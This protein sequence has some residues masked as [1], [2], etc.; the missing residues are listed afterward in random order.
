MTD[1]IGFTFGEYH[2]SELGLLRVSDGSRYHRETAGPI[3]D[4]ILEIEGSE[5]AYFIESRQEVRNLI[6]R[7]AYDDLSEEQVSLIAREFNGKEVKPLILDELPFKAYYAKVRKPPELSYVPFGT[8]LG[9]RVYKGEGT[10]EFIMHDPLAVGTGKYLLDFSTQVFPNRDEW[11]KASRMK[12]HKG[13]YDGSGTNILVYNAGDVETDLELF[14]KVDD[15]LNQQVLTK[16]IG[17]EDK[18][19]LFKVTKQESSADV[20]IRFSSHTHLAEGYDANMKRTST[21]YNKYV[22]AGSIFN[23]D[24]GEHEIE[25]TVP[26]HEARYYHRYY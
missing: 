16:I 11:A 19:L 5:R 10:I 15:V 2:S 26:C 9:E 14:F 24:K 12:T 6:M 1:Y 22:I 13:E 18:Q 3:K 20:Y 23:L 17:D 25:S 8:L 7:V 21:L 4:T